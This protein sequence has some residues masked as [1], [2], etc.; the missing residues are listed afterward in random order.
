MQRARSGELATE[1]ASP[2]PGDF[3]ESGS[4]PDASALPPGV[5]GGAASLEHLKGLHASGLIDTETFA[6][7]E[8]TMANPT[9]QL[10]QLHA[11]GAM[12]DE[13]YA[14]AL[15]S[16]PAATDPAADA[17]EMELLQ[18]GESAPATVLSLEQASDEVGAPL[19]ITLEVHPAAGDPYTA[20]CT[21]AA[22]RLGTEP[23][24][25]D[26]LRVRIDPNDPMRVA[27]DWPAFGV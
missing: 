9:A 4:V 26:F 5:A 14:Q 6:L 18:H 20:S 21:L 1:D 24:V 22:G 7:I 12:S 3:V 16:M 23:K 8:A 27:I 11:S 10:D 15:A 2:E 17:A 19:L 25:G 13:V